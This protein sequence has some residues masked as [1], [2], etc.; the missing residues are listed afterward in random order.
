MAAQNVPDQLPG[1]AEVAPDGKGGEPAS[2]HFGY[3][4]LLTEIGLVGLLSLRLKKPVE[5]DA[6][7]MKAT[8]LPEAD[9]IIRGVYRKGWELA[10]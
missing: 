1:G 3:G 9:P 10:T 2:S 4:A 8:N 7:A 5:W 6:A